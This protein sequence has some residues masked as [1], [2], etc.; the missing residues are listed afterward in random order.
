MAEIIL[1]LSLSI[2]FVFQTCKISLQV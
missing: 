2:S 1:M